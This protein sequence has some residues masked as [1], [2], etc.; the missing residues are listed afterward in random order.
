MVH[1]DNPE[2]SGMEDPEDF[3]RKKLPNWAR[4]E[5]DVNRDP[6]TGEE[7]ESDPCLWI[8]VTDSIRLDEDGMYWLS[9]HGIKSAYTDVLRLES[10][11]FASADRPW[12]CWEGCRF[13]GD[14]LR[15]ARKHV[16]EKQ[17]T[18]DVAVK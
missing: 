1:G 11:T 18:C 9:E 5:A 17:T 10:P 8:N 6:E 2:R 14:V 7:Q 12:R 4:W 3:T 15:L 16:R 13:F